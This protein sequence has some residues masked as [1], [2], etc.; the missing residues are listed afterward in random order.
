MEAEAEAV[1]LQ[2]LPLERAVLVAEAPVEQAVGLLE[3]Q[4]KLTLAAAAGVEPGEAVWVEQAAPVLS[5][6]VTQT[7]TQL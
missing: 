3:P 4:V 7:S 5:L 2:V 1:D 6:S